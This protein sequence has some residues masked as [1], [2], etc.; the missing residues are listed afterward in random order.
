M[1]KTKVLVAA[2]IASTLL[3]GAGYAAWT[4]TLTINNTVSTGEFNVKFTDAKLVSAEEGTKYLGTNATIKNTDGGV[5]KNVTLELTNLYPNAS[6]ILN[7][8]FDNT[9]TIPTVIKDVEFGFDAANGP[10]DKNLV[11]DAQKALIKVE[12]KVTYHK[13]D[14]T[15]VTKDLKEDLTTLKAGLD[16]ILPNMR[17]EM[18]EYV[19]FDNVYIKLDENAKDDFENRFVK[20][21]IGVNFKQHNVK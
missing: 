13:K 17:L 11:T 19:T 7:A 20:F 12:G 8:R 21:N 5:A 4:D 15:V 16:K 14:N 1:K 10:K 18:G 3:V 2:L 9:G 6:A